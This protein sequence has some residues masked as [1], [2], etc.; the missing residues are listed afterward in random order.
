[1]QTQFD[2]GAMLNAKPANAQYE[3]ATALNAEILNCAKTAQENLY[4]MAMGFKKMR[5][6]KLYKALGYDNFGDYCENATGMKRANVY[7]YITV[8]ERLPDDFVC[9]SI[10]NGVGFK[11][12]YMLSTLS[13][14]EREEITQTVDLENTTVKGLKAKIKE[15]ENENSDLKADCVLSDM[16]RKEEKQQFEERLNTLTKANQITQKDVENILKEKSELERH[17]ADL[18]NR[19]VEVAVKDNSEEIERLK[20]Q[21]EQAQNEL[22][23][24]TDNQSDPEELSPAYIDYKASLAIAKDALKRLVRATAAL[25]GEQDIG[26]NEEFEI[27]SVIGDFDRNIRLVFKSN[28]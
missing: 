23:E 13:E 20:H 3:A 17:I 1:M 10:Q 27:K 22:Q 15:L 12:L 7:H 19:P 26:A 11:K 18:E 8:V 5:D 14:D 6:E 21:L 4:Q 28:N 25:S 9:S 24:R 16:K 2:L